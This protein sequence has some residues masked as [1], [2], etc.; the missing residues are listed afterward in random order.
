M[1]IQSHIENISSC[2]LIQTN[3]V[4]RSSQFGSVNQTIVLQSGD[5]P[6]DEWREYRI[7]IT[8]LVST[9]KSMFYYDF[10]AKAENNRYLE[11]NGVN[12]K[13]ENNN[14][15]ICVMLDKL[16]SGSYSFT[17]TGS[18]KIIEFY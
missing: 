14:V 5:N 3:S 9:S 17:I 18:W 6:N 2:D 15:V 16:N 8:P 11:I 13:I 1:N 4:I 10:D 12:A 7:S